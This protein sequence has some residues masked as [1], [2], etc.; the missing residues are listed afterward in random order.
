MRI[1]SEEEFDKEREFDQKTTI[2]D[3]YL[4]AEGGGDDPHA[5]KCTEEDQ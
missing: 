3:Q 5:V 2:S 1:L 4:A